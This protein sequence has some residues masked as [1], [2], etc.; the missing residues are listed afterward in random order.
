MTAIT[1]FDTHPLIRLVALYEA[2]SMADG[3]VQDMVEVPA[4]YRVVR[5]YLQFDDLG[6]GTTMDVGYLLEDATADV[7]AFIDGADTAT[8][9]GTATYQPAADAKGYLFTQR[10]TVTIKNIGAS[11]TG[12]IRLEVDVKADYNSAS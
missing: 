10:G 5:A 9:A 2:S 4:G 6:T 1:S 3:T 12:S 8:A 7:D 11:A